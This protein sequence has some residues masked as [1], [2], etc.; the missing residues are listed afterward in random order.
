MLITAKTEI[1]GIHLELSVADAKDYL[2]NPK[3][4]QTEIRMILEN[5]KVELGP[6]HKGGQVADDKPEKF[7][8]ACGKEYT[9]LAWLERHQRECDQAEE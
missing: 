7:T 2:K 6:E 9:H 3:K 5:Y 4:L 1:K 8:C